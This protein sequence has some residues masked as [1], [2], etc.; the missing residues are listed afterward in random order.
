MELSRNPAHPRVPVALALATVVAVA[1]SGCGSESGHGSTPTS[2]T[3]EGQGGPGGHGGNGGEGGHGGNGGHGGSGGGGAVAPTHGGIISIQDI[4]IHGAPQAG[5]G[6]T[7]QVLLTAATAPV[8]EENPGQITGC[9][10]WSHDVQENPAPPLTDQGM[11]AIKGLEDGPINCTFQNTGY[12]CP[13][14]SGAGQASV[15]PGPMGATEYTVM[16]AAFS[17]A[18]VGRYLRV[19]GSVNG[20]NSGA[21]PIV[22]VSSAT[23]AVVVNAKAVAEEF[24]ATYTVVA[25]A[26]PV[27]GNPND[28]IAGGDELTV[29]LQPGG[30]MAFHV[31]ESGPI[32][33]GDAFVLDTASQAVIGA[34]PLDGTAVTLGCAGQG[35]SCGPAQATLV[36]ISSTDGSVAGLSPFAMPAPIDKQV[37]IQCVVVGGEGKLVIPAEAMKL[38]QDAHQA[39]PI[40][41]IRTAFMREG[42]ATLANPAPQPPNTL[43]ILVGHGLLAFTSP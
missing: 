13:A 39:T 22:A 38:L 2:S 42:V 19:T 26:G 18:D 1:V 16:G 31:P 36:R 8:Y 5:H 30:D 32:P 14:A 21:F 43:N 11:V 7:V 3:S 12:V 25:G 40:T 9:K 34:L 33:A 4:S 27:P 6:L 35:G 24:P 15:A 17:E 37:E 28:P 29:A 41:R 10:A 20:G 23:T